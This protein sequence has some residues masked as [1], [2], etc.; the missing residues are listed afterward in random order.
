MR[1]KLTQRVKSGQAQRRIAQGTKQL[2]VGV[3]TLVLSTNE[4]I[5]AV[6]SGFVGVCPTSLSAL[7]DID[8]QRIEKI[9]KYRKNRLLI[10]ICGLTALRLCVNCQVSS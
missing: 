8:G 7:G 10:A 9:K 3:G 1:R 2:P 6:E 4:A 5:S